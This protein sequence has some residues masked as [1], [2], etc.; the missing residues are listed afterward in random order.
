[1]FYGRFLS[2]RC[3]C[4]REANGSQ[5]RLVA[6]Q[7]FHSS[8]HETCARTR[9]LASRLAGWQKVMNSGW[10]GSAIKQRLPVSKQ[11]HL[12]GFSA[13]A[14]VTAPNIPVYALQLGDDRIGIGRLPPEIHLRD[15]AQ[16]L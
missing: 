10:R 9:R 13:H 15:F 6:C 7:D 4:F 11:V 12:A 2:Y 1:M 14:H 8:G 5:P 16:R 3:S